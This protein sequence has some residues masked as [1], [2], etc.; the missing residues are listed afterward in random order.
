[1]K[2]GQMRF[3]LLNKPFRTWQLLVPAFGI[4]L[5]LMLVSGLAT[6]NR[7]TQLYNTLSD[8][9]RKYRQ[10]WRGLDNL[11]S[12]IHVSSVLV[13]D[14][15]LDPSLSRAKE[16]REALLKE[17]TATEE[18]LRQIERALER[19]HRDKLVQLRTEINA[20]W[21]SLD[22]VFDWSP[23]EK[24][25]AAYGFLRYR[26]MPR[27]DA[28]LSLAEEIQHFTDTTFQRERA[29]MRTNEE[30]FRSFLVRTMMS[31]LGLG[32]IVAFISVLRVSVL[33]RRAELHRQRTEQ[34]EN[35][36]RRLS[37]QLVYSQ[38]EERRSI[39]RELHDEVGQL[40]TGLRMELRT[41][42]KVHRSDPHDFDS[43]VEQTRI[44]LEQTLQSVRD[45]AM[46]LRPSML[47]D[48]G[49]EAALQWQIRQFERSHEIL[50]TLRVSTNLDHLP[51]RHI[52]NLYRIVQEALTNCARHSQAHA[53]E[54]ELSEHTGALRLVI[55]DDGVGM[56]G[57]SA[58]GLGLVGIQERVRE[59][60]G[61]FQVQSLQG[62]GTAII[63]DLPR[64]EIPAYG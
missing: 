26:I 4:L 60:D 38:E 2:S 33:E 22:P 43:R 23:E 41:L 61:A 37:H 34:A 11:R 19:D 58:A 32:L 27:R 54:I 63:V 7:T 44:L 3:Q 25:A 13:R 52:T 28:V 46:G 35:E 31:I 59:L 42:Q 9:N 14:Y 62:K 21:E 56:T 55:R 6:L 24:Q 45:I 51:E 64:H 8:L 53:V 10:D 57:K 40:L 39:S 47:D 18:S 29:E 1:M 16:I 48:L 36:M 12:G 50:V 15:L 20:Y 5:A 49:L 17:R 30:R